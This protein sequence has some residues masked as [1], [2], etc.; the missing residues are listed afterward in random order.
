[1]SQSHSKKRIVKPPL[2]RFGGVRVVQRRVQ[3]SEII[4]HNKESVAKELVDV[5]VPPP[6][7]LAVFI[8]AVS[9]QE[10]PL[11]AQVKGSRL[12]TIQHCRSRVRVDRLRLSLSSEAYTR[13]DRHRLA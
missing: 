2:D 4:E 13:H 9:D 3:K 7:C 5:P 12:A 11:C 8:S 10:E 1:M 6:A